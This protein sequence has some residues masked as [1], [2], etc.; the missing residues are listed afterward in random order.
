MATTASLPRGEHSLES[1]E[2]R[3][4]EY[5]TIAWNAV[6]AI[7]AVTAGVV[8]GSTALVGFGVDSVIESAS[9]SVLLWRLQDSDDHA[10]REALAL[11]LVGLTFLILGAWVGFE[12]VQSLLAREAPSVSYVGIGVAALSLLPWIASTAAACSARCRRSTPVC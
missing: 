12:S 1:A 6:E 11:R 9:G 5:L 7:V 8:A 3:R 4:L 2:G 10:Q